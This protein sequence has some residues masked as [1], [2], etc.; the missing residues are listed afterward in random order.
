MYI[1]PKIKGTAIYDYN[2]LVNSNF[3]DKI[4]YKKGAK[5]YPTGGGSPIILK[6]LQINKY[7]VKAI[8]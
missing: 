8:K 2:L 4:N 6:N 1:D 5:R 3:I 7:G